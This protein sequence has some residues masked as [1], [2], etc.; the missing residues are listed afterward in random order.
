MRDP[1]EEEDSAGFADQ[2]PMPVVVII[3]AGIVLG[4]WSVAWQ[5]AKALGIV[6]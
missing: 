4:F 6:S 5:A 3:C 2:A 1:I